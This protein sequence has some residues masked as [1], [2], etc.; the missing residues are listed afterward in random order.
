MTSTPCPC[1]S[2]EDRRGFL[3]KA[4]A[5]VIGAVLGTVP[6][7]AGLTVLFA[8]LQRRRR[9]EQ[10]VWVGTLGAL[11]Q[12]GSPCRFPVVASRV[13]AW[14]KSQG[15]V[16][17]V[18]LRRVESGVIAL[19]V[20]CPHAGCFVDYSASRDG[21]VCPCHN[22]S[23]NLDGTIRDPRSPAPRGLDTLEVEIRDKNQLWVKFQN[24]RAG[25]ARKAVA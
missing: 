18:Y 5:T 20:A 17:A 12:D 22:S 7:G 11:P 4:L 13:D 6:L 15:V 24:F 9:Q 23:F 16:G 1:S 8:P 19:N 3:K 21:F 25:E 10:A 14:N 2:R